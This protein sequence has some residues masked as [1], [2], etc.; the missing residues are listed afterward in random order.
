MPSDESGTRRQRILLSVAIVILAGAS[1]LAWVR[2]GGDS[3]A[4]IAAERAYICID[5]GEVYE[6]TIKFGDKSPYRSPYTKQNTGY[7]A[8]ACYWTK[9]ENGRWSR[10]EQPTFV[11]VKKEVDPATTEKTYC[12][13]CGREVVR[14]NIPPTEKNIAEANAELDE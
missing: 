7:R 5:T 6:Y 8:D 12:P 14:H 9:D 4:D 11:L 2:L 10:K 3:P 13:D 1:V